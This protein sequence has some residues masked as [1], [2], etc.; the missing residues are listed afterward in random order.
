MP[1]GQISVRTMASCYNCYVHSGSIVPFVPV[2]FLF[3]L[4][5]QTFIFVVC[6]ASPQPRELRSAKRGAAVLVHS[7][8]YRVTFICFLTA[9]LF[10]CVRVCLCVR[11]MLTSRDGDW[12]Y[13]ENAKSGYRG[14]I[15]ANY[16]AEV[17]SIKHFEYVSR[18][19]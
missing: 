7:A 6:D 3:L 12:W 8:S 1:A 17:N 10:V 13:V 5:S 2:F 18:L 19:G 16:V 9:Y 4:L 15:P 14:Y 11:V